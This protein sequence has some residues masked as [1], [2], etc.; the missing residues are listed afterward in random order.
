MSGRP[1]AWRRPEGVDASLWAYMQSP[2]VAA[3]EAGEEGSAPLALFD[4]QVVER[5]LPGRQCIVDLGC[6]T[7]RISL[8]LGQSGHSVVAVDLA[9]VSLKRLADRIEAVDRI[10][11]I[12]G[13]LGRLSMLRAG[14]FDAALLMYSTLGMVR[15]RANRIRILAGAAEAVRTDGTLIVHAHNFWATRSI[16]VITSRIGR[17]GGPG[18]GWLDRLG[19]VPMRYAGVPNVVIHAYRWNELCADL[20]GGGWR[21]V[22][23]LALDRGSGG[24]LPRPRFAH[25]WRADGWIVRAIK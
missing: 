10:L 13:D 16:G 14:A 19:D 1:P 12:R 8:R 23:V 17:A 4:Q 11:P 20:V 25:A 21:K 2:D 22:E 15:G 24:P 3:L 9:K 5:W 7:G 18:R 6:G